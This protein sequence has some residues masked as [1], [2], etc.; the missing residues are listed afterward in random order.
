MQTAGI[1]DPV[2]LVLVIT[3]SLVAWFVIPNFLTKRAMKKVIKMLSDRNITSAQNAK[4]IQELGLTPHTFVQS[5][6]LARDY[7]PA[8]LKLLIEADIIRETKDGR[9]YISKEKLD[10]Y[11]IS[12]EV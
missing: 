9:V 11:R 8:A 3:L 12:K 2:V 7:K 6:Y 4:T 10:D 1:S 5:L